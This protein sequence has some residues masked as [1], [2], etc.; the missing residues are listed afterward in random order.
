MSDAVA[1]VVADANVYT[2]VLPLYTRVWPWIPLCYKC[3]KAVVIS[4]TDSPIIT[5]TNA[6][7]HVFIV[8]GSIEFRD[9][10]NFFVIFE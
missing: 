4:L 1:D 5:N 8:F 3:Y 2:H 7:P 9:L 6:S 10:K